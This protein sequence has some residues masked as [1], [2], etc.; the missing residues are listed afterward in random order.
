MKILQ[1][2]DVDVYN[3]KFAGQNLHSYLNNSGHDSW[4]LVYTQKTNDFTTSQI[5]SDTVQSQLTLENIKQIDRNYGVHCFSGNVPLD[6]LRNRHFLDADVVHYHLIHNYF[7]NYN[8]L[9]MLSSLKPSVLTLHDPWM[10]TGHCVY[11]GQCDRWKTGCGSCPDLER[12]FRLEYDTT[13]LNWKLKRLAIKNSNVDFVVASRWMFDLLDEAKIIS[14]DRVHHVPYGI[15]TDIF[16]VK[17]KENIRSSLGIEKG[18]F[19]IGFRSD[20]NENKGFEYIEHLLS[21]I[22]SGDKI[23][24]IALAN[25]GLLEKYSDKFKIIEVGWVHGDELLSDLY[26]A[27]DLFLMP[28]T[29]EAFGMMAIES[30]A[31]GTP[32][33]CL[34][35]TSLVEVADCPN[36]GFVSKRDRDS[37]V[38]LVKNIIADKKQIITRAEL[39]AKRVEREFGLSLYLERLL[40]VYNVSMGRYDLRNA[41][42]VLNELKYNEINFKEKTCEEKRVGFSGVVKKV[43]K[44]ILNIIIPKRLKKFICD[45]K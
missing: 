9:P 8:Y 2:G 35:G 25:K 1:V 22:E 13:A 16:R 21:R 11:P 30:Q 7:F 34:E 26:N 23:T 10:I 3:S 6:I 44:K 29:A 33:V 15:D 19:V 36:I 18:Q 43:L 20:L 31:C 45:C 41:F 27:M 24:L 28:S 37:F 4:S 14:L 17:N 5:I 42:I 40:N 12:T 39:G 38:E 32:V